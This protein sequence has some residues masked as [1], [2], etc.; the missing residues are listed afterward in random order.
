MPLLLNSGVI[1]YEIA[2]GQRRLFYRGSMKDRR[3]GGNHPFYIKKGITASDSG[4][5][6]Q[7]RVGSSL[8]ALR[9]RG[10]RIN[11]VLITAG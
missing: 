7:R 5:P 1:F 6:V 4:L 9:Q 3:P 11:I 8:I 2:P 10:V